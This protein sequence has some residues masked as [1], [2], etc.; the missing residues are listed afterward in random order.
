MDLDIVI[1]DFELKSRYYVYFRTNTIGIDMN[2]LIPP[3]M[4]QI[5]PLLCLHKG[6]FGIK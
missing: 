2:S 1:S 5:A 6:G 3:D 4:G